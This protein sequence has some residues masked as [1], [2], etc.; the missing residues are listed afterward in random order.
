MSE[1]PKIFYYSILVRRGKEIDEIT[2]ALKAGVSEEILNWHSL[3]LS[4]S[5]DLCIHFYCLSRLM[6]ASQRKMIQS[7][8][9]IIRLRQC[10]FKIS[11]D[12]PAFSFGTNKTT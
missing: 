2:Q 8:A 9:L 7:L 5:A 1:F 12:T 11:S 4:L 10:Q 3:C 6:Q